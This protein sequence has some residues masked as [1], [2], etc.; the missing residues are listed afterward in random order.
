MGPLDL[1]QQEHTQHQ[2]E[3]LQEA[4]Q[5][6]MAEHSYDRYGRRRHN[7]VRYAIRHAISR[8]GALLIALGTKLER[9]EPA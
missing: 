7:V 9:V 5:R 4:E 6:R 3:L 2:R 1:R 8:V